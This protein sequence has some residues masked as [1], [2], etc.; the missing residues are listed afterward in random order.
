M[1]SQITTELK[2]WGVPENKIFFEAFGPATVKKLCPAKPATASKARPA[3][4]KVTF[5]K[6]GKSCQWKVGG[7]SILELAE[8]NGITM[9]FG[10]RAG[11]CGTCLTAVKAGKVEHEI[12][13]GAKPEEGS[14]LACVGEPASDLVLDA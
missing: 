10:C 13:A 1:M 12:E 14:C 8:A 2:A 7:G 3:S 5:A 11:N 9:D 4:C 6:S